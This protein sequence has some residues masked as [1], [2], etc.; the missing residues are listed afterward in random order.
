MVVGG[1]A[2][3]AIVGFG[4]VGAVVV[5]GDLA[6]TGL[7]LGPLP[8]VLAASIETSGVPILMG[9]GH[10]D[11]GQTMLGYAV[12]TQA[13]LG[14]VCLASW[15][16]RVERPWAPLF[17]PIEGV[18]LALASMGCSALAILDLSDRTHVQTY[19][20]ANLITFVATGFLMPV[21]A[22]LLVASLRRPARA[23]A[24]TACHEARK[25][26]WRFQ[27]LALL[28]AAAVGGAYYLV[29]QRTGLG[30]EDSEVMWATLTQWVLVAET[31]VATLLWASRR[32]EGRHRVVM[33]GAAVVALQ[34][35]FAVGVYGL[36]V[37]HVAIHHEAA[38]PL[39][40]GM[41]VSSY[42]IVFLVLLWAAG[43]GLM[44]AAL[45]R[46]R[47]R[48]RAEKE[49]EEKAED[50]QDDEEQDDDNG[51]PRHWLH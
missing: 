12:I 7:L 13:L 44:L 23:A 24:V 40:L 6:A 10:A 42:W 50:E 47:D 31:A 41:D 8:A 21:L 15:R 38:L 35:A 48:A 46:D 17:R 29:M 37:E 34:I 22:W 30:K 2:A 27:G 16:R 49:A 14:L 45:L 19:D 32:R 3:L 39:L 28:T 18:V 20:S 1:L 33:L 5:I 4:L 36:E 9:S 11:M 26:F 25:A 43:L 51:Q